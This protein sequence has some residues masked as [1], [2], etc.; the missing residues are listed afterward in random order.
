MCRR[1]V[2]KKFQLF[3]AVD[4]TTNPQSEHTSVSQLDFITYEVL[5]D[6]SVNAFLKVYYCND[7]V[8]NASNIRELDFGSPVALLGS[9]D[10]EYTL[11]IENMGFKWL[12]LEVTNNAG[13]GDVSAWITGNVR[14]A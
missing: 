1:N 14:G 4:S 12:L 5:I 9:N 8:F 13:T 7:E 3:N 2:L 11:H 10:T 6:S